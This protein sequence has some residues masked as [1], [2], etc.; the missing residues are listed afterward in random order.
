MLKV[1]KFGGSSLSDSAQFA[2]VK[3]IV[4]SDDARKV[5]VVSAPG[6]RTSD[7]NKITDLLY[8][9]KAHLKY[10]VSPDP[11]FEMI[12]ARYREIRDQL[13]LTLDV[14]S[15]LAEIRSKMTKNMSVD[16]LVSRG[17]YLNAK[18]MAEY[19]GY[20]F[21]D[22]ADWVAFGYDGKV[23]YE[24]TEQQL[25]EIYNVYNRIVVPGFYGSLPSGQIH[26]FSRGGSDVTGAFAAASLD[27]D[28]Y[29]NW[30]DVTGILMVDPRIVSNPKTISRVTYAELRELSYMGAAV[31]HEDTV[32]PVRRKDIPV[33]IRNTNDPEAEGT[34]IRES[35]EADNAEETS[36]FITGITGKKDFSI[37][38]LHKANMSDAVG[39]IRRV[40]EVLEQY[41]IP[42]AQIPSGIDSFSLVVPT[43]KLAPVKYDLISDIKRNCQITDINVQDDISLIAIVG[44]QMAYRTG[45]SGKIFGALG[46]NRINI[47]T[48]EQSS[49]EINIM[50]GVSTKDFEKTIQV[51]YES[52]AK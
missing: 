17:E 33:N 4:E 2:K 28:I 25:R 9:C 44:R 5:V 52:F 8:L 21:V 31:L 32:V 37:I 40:L 39:A 24:K 10:D 19:L 42:I 48:I 51:L 15:E 14:D 36:R 47:R 1:A 7:D 18:L 26:T 38:S 43:D 35:F 16:Y 11:I 29:E 49:D 22:S 50:V 23:D 34:I 6:R 3:H 20:H 30:T 12:S 41:R 45:I 46:A 27:A 13:G